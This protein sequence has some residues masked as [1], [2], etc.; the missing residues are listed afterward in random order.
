[1]E[2][3]SN[4][5]KNTIPFQ[6]LISRLQCFWTKVGCM[7]I[8]P[9]DI[10]V[11]AGTSHPMCFLNSIGPE[12]TAIAYIQPSRRPSDG[13]FGKPTNR[14]QHY[15]QFQVA[16]K[17]AP[18]DI[19]DIYIKSIESLDIDLRY[20][21]LRFVDDNWENPTLATWGIGWEVWLNGLEVTQLT[22]FQQVGGLISKPVT[23]EITYGLERLAMHIQEVNNIYA[24]SWS[25]GL[26]GYVSYGEMFLKSEIDHSIYSFEYSDLK[27]LFSLFEIHMKEV[28]KLLR[29][30]KVLLGSAY[31]FVLKA[32]HI[33]NLLD[34]RNALSTTER[35]SHIMCIRS[36]V[37]EIA[38][39]YYIY[40][41]SIGFPKRGII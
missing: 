35:K 22:Y 18:K 2:K 13:R 6:E 26:F 17:P 7:L 34:A 23:T 32:V 31:E 8:Q 12:P 37:K 5:N 41:K 11:G 39:K 25:A 16:I 14:L 24:I 29:F 19:Q 40:R 28:Q 20:N 27:L 3:S 33:F 15:Y 10:E 21:D 38:K 30:T 1:M 9:I 4:K 36:L